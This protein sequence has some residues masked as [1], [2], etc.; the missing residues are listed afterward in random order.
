MPQAISPINSATISNIDCESQKSKPSILKRLVSF[1]NCA[2]FPKSFHS[3]RDYYNEKTHASLADKIARSRDKKFYHALQ[4]SSDS[5]SKYFDIDI[6]VKK[7]FSGL[8][9]EFSQ[10]Y[11]RYYTKVNNINELRR[12]MSNLGYDIDP[13][14]QVVSVNINLYRYEN[15]THS[16]EPYNA[17]NRGDRRFSETVRDEIC[18]LYFKK[19]SMEQ[20]VSELREKFFNYEIT[21]MHQRGAA[22]TKSASD[23][24]C[25]FQ[26]SIKTNKDVFRIVAENISFSKVEAEKKLT[27]EEK[28]EA[29]E[30]ISK[31]NQ[32]DHD[33]DSF[34]E[35]LMKCE[36]QS[37]TSFE[38]DLKSKVA[39]RDSLLNFFANTLE[40]MV[41]KIYTRR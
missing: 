27:S 19:S 14:K 36:L 7:N 13:I 26:F 38:A 3:N 18:R 4:G 12:K 30:F 2:A 40:V 33:I 35:Q 29:E 31:R 39:E 5:I 21:I 11:E 32:L 16:I 22:N 17:S 10:A 28:A 9:K 20:M 15:V 6:E 37:N 24:V 1:F 8:V 23:A 41:N 34:K 25:V